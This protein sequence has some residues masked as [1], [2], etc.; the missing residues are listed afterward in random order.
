MT[1]SNHHPFN[2]AY[3]ATPPAH[4]IDLS[5]PEIYRNFLRG[6]YYTDHAVGQ[7]FKK[8]ARRPWFEQT[9]FVIASDHGI[10]VH[11]R[12]LNKRTN[13][14]Q[15]KEIFY[16]SPLL[17]LGPNI[18]PRRLDIVASQIDVAPT[19]LDLL[20]IQATHSFMGTS[21]LADVPAQ[22]RFAIMSASND[23]NIRIGNRYCYATNRPCLQDGFPACPDAFEPT[24]RQHACFQTD[25][26]LLK[27]GDPQVGPSMQLLSD[28]QTQE[29]TLHGDRLVRFTRFLYQNDAVFPPEP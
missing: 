25:K 15:E 7:L 3:S 17:I 14:A 5:E 4:S 18:Q 16:R 20:N 26:D 13:P 27:L 24:P 28:D 8:A 2:Y 22:K 12:A 23:W 6:S 1:L 21:L 29:L 19:L 11:P 9:I 10:R